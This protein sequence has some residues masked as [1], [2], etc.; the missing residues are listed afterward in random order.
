MNRLFPL[1]ITT[2]VVA[3]P[4]CQQQAAEPAAADP[5]LTGPVPEGR[6]RGTVLETMDS[7]GYTYAALDLD[8]EVRWIAGPQTALQTGDVVLTGVGMPM[9][10][11]SSRTLSRTFDIIFFVG[12]IENLSTPAAPATA[13]AVTAP[14]PTL[15]EGHP[16]IEREAAATEVDMEALEPGKDIAWLYAN[17]ESLAGQPVTLRGQV[18]K[19]NSG[20]L[21]WNFVHLKDGSGDAATGTNDLT[22]TTHATTAVGETVVVTGTVVLDKDFGAG[23]RFPLLLEDAAIEAE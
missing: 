23:Y 21:G 16:P 13:A 19:Y 7:G 14:D 18:V 22:V 3:L 9:N 17:R 5:R 4:A 2:L 15:P 1:L 6:V 11:F 12:E 10:D 8:G 20:I